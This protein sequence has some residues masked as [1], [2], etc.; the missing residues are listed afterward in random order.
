MPSVVLSHWTVGNHLIKHFDWT[1][2]DQMRLRYTPAVI[3]VI[4]LLR[5]PVD[6]AVS[7]FNF[8][9]RDKGWATKLL[10]GVT[11]DQFLDN[12]DLMMEIRGIWQDGQASVSWLTGTHIGDSWVLHDPVKGLSDILLIFCLSL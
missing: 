4:T 5:H 2:I 10:S 9:K 1:V 8:V 7:H 6:R 12:I 11:I 3:D